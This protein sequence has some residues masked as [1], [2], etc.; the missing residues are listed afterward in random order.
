M[1]LAVIFPLPDGETLRNPGQFVLLVQVAYLQGIACIVI[2][3]ADRG[4]TLLHRG[5]VHVFIQI[6]LLRHPVPGIVLIFHS[7]IAA[8]NPDFF[9]IQV[10][11]IAKTVIR[12][13]VGMNDPVVTI[14]QLSRLSF[15]DIPGLFRAVSV[16]IP[17]IGNI[18]PLVFLQN[19][20]AGLTKIPLA[21]QIPLLIPGLY[22]PGIALCRND[23]VAVPIGKLLCQQ[24]ACLIVGAHPERITLRRDDRFSLQT[25]I[26]LREDI[27]VVIIRIGCRRIVA[28][29]HV[30]GASLIEIFLTKK[31]VLIVILA[32][33]LSGAG[34]D[35]R[36]VSVLSA[37]FLADQISIQVI[38]PYE[39]RI[40][41]RTFCRI[42]VCVEVALFQLT[43]FLVPGIL[44]PLV[45]IRDGNRLQFLIKVG[46]A[47]T[48]APAVIRLFTAR[49]S[50]RGHDRL[51]VL[52]QIHDRGLHAVLIVFPNQDRIPVFIDDQAAVRIIAGFFQD[53]SIGITLALKSGIARRSGYDRLTVFIKVCSPQEVPVQVIFLLKRSIPI[54]AQ[55]RIS[56]GIQILDPAYKPGSFIVFLPKGSITL[57]NHDRLSI[58]TEVCFVDH[59]LLIVV[60]AFDLCLS[61][62]EHQIIC[63]IVIGDPGPVAA[64]VIPIAARG[65]SIRLDQCVPAGSEVSVSGQMICKVIRMNLCSILSFCR[66]HPAV[67]PEIDFPEQLPFLVVLTVHGCIPPDNLAGIPFLIE[68][69]DG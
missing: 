5:P 24:V 14:G 8:C 48:V 12:R 67:F 9:L 39:G 25:K 64:P 63:C 66:H 29:V 20:P 3:I 35:I 26:S 23:Q 56:L 7:R 58:R 49:V 2:H 22:F 28:T 33:N 69:A 60:F 4:V 46:N 52:V 59:M 30:G 34:T 47:G 41:V 44:C 15:K 53:I 62:Y 11:D 68:V 57:L 42:S 38:L 18:T 37:V 36:D 45:T 65:I 13:I 17:C 61:V 10:I 50:V 55:N 43:A 51:P 19:V 31:P 6:T 27:A 54:R 16:L 1:V 32:Q 40:A 21:G